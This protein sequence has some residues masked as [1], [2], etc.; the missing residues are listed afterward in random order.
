MVACWT[1][2]SCPSSPSAVSA[3]FSL[4]RYVLVTCLPQLISI[5]LHPSDHNREWRMLD[6]LTASET[7]SRRMSVSNK[8]HSHSVRGSDGRLVHV[9]DAHDEQDAQHQNHKDAVLVPPAPKIVVKSPVR[10]PSALT[11]FICPI[12]SYWLRTASFISAST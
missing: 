1:L 3:S 9:V 5:M 4:L 7:P 6:S 2:A 11:H 12:F 10:F 8:K